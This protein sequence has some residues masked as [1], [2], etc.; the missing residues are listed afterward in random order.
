MVKTL[1]NNPELKKQHQLWAGLNGQYRDS[2]KL[3]EN[4][5]FDALLE[6]IGKVHD[7]AV[8]IRKPAV[9][10][11]GRWQP[12]KIRSEK[13]KKVSEDAQLY[14]QAIRALGRL[15]TALGGGWEYVKQTRLQWAG[16]REDRGARFLA[17][18]HALWSE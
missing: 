2:G 18:D 4:A 15:E 9:R 1:A 5:Q 6:L 12:E 14:A 16:Q 17:Y 3:P 13:G 11:Y 10:K 7:D 8:K